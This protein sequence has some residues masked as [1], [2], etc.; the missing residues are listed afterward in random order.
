VLETLSAADRAEVVRALRGRELRR[1]YR[2]VDGFRPVRLT[3]LVP[4]V[5]PALTPVR[6]DGKNSMPA[7]TWFEKRF[8]RLPGTDP[9]APGE[10]CGANFQTLSPITGPGYFVALEDSPRG[11]VVLDYTKLPPEAPEGWK[12]IRDNQ[13]GLA[14]LFYGPLR[15]TLRRVSEH[16]TVG[17]AARYG[18]EISWFALCRQEPLP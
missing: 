18:R 12:P 8:A 17:V 1:L 6:H 13:H 5:V 14:W 7:F 3:D 4:P 11:E 2:A 9:R 10:L 15:D 16:V